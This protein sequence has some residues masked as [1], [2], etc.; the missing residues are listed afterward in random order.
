MTSPA[1]FSADL[2][3]VGGGISGMSAAAACVAA[4]PEA[5][6]VLLDRGRRF[7]GR[8]A[9]RTLRSGPWASH[10]VDL[11]AAY[12]TVSDPG[13]AAV[14]HDWQRRGLARPWTETFAVADADGITG[15]TSGPT[16][17]AAGTDGLRGLVEDLATRLPA[18]VVTNH[19]CEV[20][21][22]APRP[23]GGWDVVDTTG[24]RRWAVDRVALCMPPPQAA[25]LLDAESSLAHACRG[26]SYEPILALVAQ[27]PARVWDD[28][29][30]CFVNDH[31]V[32]SFVADDGSRRGD[33]AAVLVAHSTPAFARGYLDDPASAAPALTSAVCTLLGLP[34][35]VAVEVKR[36]SMARPAGTNPLVRD[37]ESRTGSAVDGPPPACLVDSR[38]RLGIASDAFDPRPR[39]EAAWL[40]GRDLG[41]ILSSAAA[42]A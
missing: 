1:D 5:R 42:T 4:A 26:S 24:N 25:T 20:G 3:V 13:F 39:V 14:V 23:A 10:V 19:P 28:F 18:Q 40:S 31:E 9:A 15:L 7:G 6:V 35:P 41:T 36:W 37:Q 34:A 38:Q 11:G 33:G 22:L 8:M 32:V 27:W 30:G 29:H 21:T 17:W 2:L 16:R 12:F